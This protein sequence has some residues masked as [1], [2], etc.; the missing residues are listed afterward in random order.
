M[1]FAQPFQIQF[2]VLS[3]GVFKIKQL[4]SGSK[5]SDFCDRC[6]INYSLA[7]VPIE[8]FILLDQTQPT[9]PPD[10]IFS[11]TP[12]FFP[13]KISRWDIRDGESLNSM[14]LDL[15]NQLIQ[16]QKDWIK[17]I[18]DTALQFEMETMESIQGT[19]FY[20]LSEQ[21]IVYVSLPLTMFV[22]SASLI[23][24]FPIL[25]MQYNLKDC[26]RSH[27]IALP[28]NWPSNYPKSSD[29]PKFDCDLVI[30]YLPIL[31]SFW[32]KKKKSMQLKH[33]FI[34]IF[35]NAFSNQI[36]STSV[37][38]IEFLFNH[39]DQSAIIKLEL[40][41]EFPSSPPILTI[42]P[43]KN[44]SEKPK[45]FKKIDDMPWSPRWQPEEIFSKVKNYIQKQLEQKEMSIK[46]KV[47]NFANFGNISGW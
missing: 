35:K 43:L 37:I 10:F 3:N 17:K 14:I 33:Q 13:S 1:A 19:E 11:S 2:A 45:E 34:E 9:I 22:D 36:I 4:F 26:V 39:G 41:S 7:G 30:D 6:L 47:A 12:D 28:P 18:C 31:N 44:E 27:S 38:S 46:N 5:N 25:R 29:F 40:P 8:W 20:C 15:R 16:C 24:D 42:M 21:D 32:E 23:K